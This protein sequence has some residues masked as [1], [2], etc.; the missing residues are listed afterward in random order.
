MANGNDG[1]LITGRAHDNIIGGYHN[2]VIPQ[3]TFSGNT[4]YGLA[5]TGQAYNNQ[6]FNTAIGTNSTI[7]SGFGNSHGGLLISSTGTNNLIGGVEGDPAMPPADYISGNT[8]NG[9][10]I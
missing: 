3:S 5:I 10:T 6:V 9:V 2:S 7:T 1:L 4:A 8:G